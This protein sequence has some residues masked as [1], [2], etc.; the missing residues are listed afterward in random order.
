MGVPPM[1]SLWLTYYNLINAPRGCKPIEPITQQSAFW[2]QYGMV[3][4]C[5]GDIWRVPW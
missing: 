4:T 3:P 1:R 5:R 2:V